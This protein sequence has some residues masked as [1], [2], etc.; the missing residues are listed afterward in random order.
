MAQCA[1]VRESVALSS[2]GWQYGVTMCRLHLPTQR[3]LANSRQAPNLQENWDS[4]LP[5]NPAT[6]WCAL[7]PHITACRICLQGAKV[8]E[9]VSGDTVIVKDPNGH[10][11][12]LS[13]ARFVMAGILN[14]MTFGLVDMIVFVLQRFWFVF[15]SSLG[16]RDDVIQLWKGLWGSGKVM[17]GT[18]PTRWKRFELWRGDH[19]L[20][21]M[22]WHCRG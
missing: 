10:D 6:C 15:S 4:S 11:I 5:S 7:V 20:G 9:V 2:L 17:R 13:L 16:T 19:W 8:V 18:V 14:L 3:W 22:P 1:C 21:G 12:R